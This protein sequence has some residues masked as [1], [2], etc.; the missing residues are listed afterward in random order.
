MKLLAREEIFERAKPVTRFCSVYFL[1][2]GTQIVYVG[3]SCLG[4]ERLYSHH[5]DKDFDSYSY[6]IC[7]QDEVDDLEAEYITK[8][9]PLYNNGYLTKNAKYKALGS[10]TKMFS[11]DRNKLK[12]ILHE[13]GLKPFNGKYYNVDEA[14]KVISMLDRK[15]KNRRSFN[16]TG[17]CF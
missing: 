17:N 4:Y 3:K 9:N 15:N 16:P 6:I 7:E 11:M 13:H 1:F 5:K 8:F 10:L 2:K 14:T 12:N